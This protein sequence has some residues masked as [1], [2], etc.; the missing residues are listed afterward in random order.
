M[1]QCKEQVLHVVID[2]S[3]SHSVLVLI[4]D[5]KSHIV[6]NAKA[7]KFNMILVKVKETLKTVAEAL[8]EEN[9]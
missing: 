3:V 2:F 8:S 4:L 5:G 9:Y 7:T 6:S 1:H